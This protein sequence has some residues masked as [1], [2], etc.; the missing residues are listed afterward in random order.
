MQWGQKEPSCDFRPSPLTLGS[1]QEKQGE[2]VEVFTRLPYEERNVLRRMQDWDGV[3]D[4]GAAAPV[5]SSSCPDLS[6]TYGL[7]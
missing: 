2:F 7:I 5:W 6:W 1:Q 3:G 4:K